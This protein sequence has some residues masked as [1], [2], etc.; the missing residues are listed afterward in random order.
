MNLFF[1]FK[2]K[3]KIITKNPKKTVDIAP[4]IKPSQVFFGESCIRGVLPK[5]K[6][7][8]YAIISLHMIIETGT[9]SLQKK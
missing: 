6:P 5:K 9:R 8:M 7:N 2:H 1:I 4:P 3:N